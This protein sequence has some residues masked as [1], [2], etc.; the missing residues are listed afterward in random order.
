MFQDR[1]QIAISQV[2]KVL[3]V[4][5]AVVAGVGYYLWTNGILGANE[6]AAA[7]TPPAPPTAALTTLF[8]VPTEV[9]GQAPEFMYYQLRV[10]DHAPDF[11]LQVLDRNET[12]SLA[13]FAGQPVLINFWASWC[14]PCRTEMP[15]LQRVYEANKAGGLVLLGINLTSQD[16][17][18]EARA[19]VNEFRLTFPILLDETG[20][21][22]DGPYRVL[23]LPM[24][25]LVDRAGIVKRIQ[26]GAMT[27]SQ[28][29]EYVAELLR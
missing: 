28:M 16:T 11:T 14:V 2:A 22:S 13:Q 3:G 9:S 6:A 1:E 21:V 20:E 7:A 4:V 27:R 5:L 23:G 17:I 19:F 12:M 25:V 18:T 29:E 8:V 15:D 26:I 24:S 10:G